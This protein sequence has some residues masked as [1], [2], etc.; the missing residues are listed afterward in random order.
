MLGGGTQTDHP[1]N[2]G[3][4]PDEEL[5]TGDGIT[6]RIDKEGVEMKD[7]GEIMSQAVNQ[8]RVVVGINTGELYPLAGEDLIKGKGDTNEEGN[9]EEYGDEHADKDIRVYL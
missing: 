9:A 3:L 6:A 5:E 1:D 7:V 8:T 4:Y 2:D